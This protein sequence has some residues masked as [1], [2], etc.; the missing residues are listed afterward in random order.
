[1][2]QDE[3][4]EL[5]KEI[6]WVDDVVLTEHDVECN[7]SSV[8]NELKKIKPHIFA[9]GGDRKLDNIPEVSVCNEIGCRMAFNAGRGGKVQSSSWLLKNHNENLNN[10]KK[11]KNSK[12]NV[13]I[14]KLP[15]S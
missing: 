7:D 15:R 3:R 12:F 13:Q 8:C 1:M 11:K 4:A 9:N 2:P 5:L 6:R 14:K 10:L